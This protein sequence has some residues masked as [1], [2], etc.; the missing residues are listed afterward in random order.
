MGVHVVDIL[1]VFAYL[2][3]LGAVGAYFSR[4]QQSL[5]GYLSAHRSMAWLPVGLSLMAALN[6][7]IDYL[8]QPSATIRYGLVL[9]VGTLSWI[10]LYFWVSRVAFPFYHRLD[11]Y[12]A[13]EYLEAR[14]DVRVRTL[15]AA[16]FVLWRLGWMATALYVP[17]LAVAAATGGAVDLITMIVVLGAL[18]TIYTMLGGMQAVI[19][20]DVMQ[21][22]IMFGGLAATVGIVLV[23]VPGGLPQV[24]E[25]AAAAGKTDLWVPI[26]NVLTQPVTVPALLFALIVGRAAQYT[27]DQVMVQRL[28]TTRSITDA[29]RAFAIH[30]AGDVV[31]MIGLSLVGLAL[32][33]YFQYRPPTSE[34]EPDRVLPYFMAEAFPIGATGLVIAAILAASLS[35]ID[36]AIHS[37]SAVL[38]IDG[39]YRLGRGRNIVR[40]SIAREDEPA[41]LRA[42]RVATLLVGLAGTL[43][44][45]NVVRIGNLL[46]IA[47][48]LIN[49]FTGPLLGI[50]LLAMFSRRVGARSVLLGGLAGAVAS[51]Y[52]AYHSTLSFYWPSTAGLLATLLG[53]YAS[54]RIAPERIEES[55]LRLTWTGVLQRPVGR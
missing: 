40:G 45:T 16:I 32:F 11:Y 26:T 21:F 13:Y 42:T 2:L 22:C 24:M 46:E 55:A 20:N 10:P 8:T 17:C 19:W 36:S 54:A 38:V 5:D 25:S 29:R 1:V 43:L 3:A 18:V 52:V 33:A 28:Q 41:H 35:S 14:F 47:N 34:I 30:A 50:Y 51:Y 27:S 7:G 39:Y 6:S 53:G 31:W 4:R 15:A 48:K 9:I 44:A 23:N 49:S 12:T 37:C